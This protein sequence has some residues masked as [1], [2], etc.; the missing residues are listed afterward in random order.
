MEAHEV[1]K[2][3]EYAHR[4]VMDTIQRFVINPR[5]ETRDAF[6][7]FISDNRRIQAAIKACELFIAALDKNHIEFIGDEDNV[8]Q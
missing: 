7:K 8:P 1:N 2:D 5:V 3:D 4:V 6:D